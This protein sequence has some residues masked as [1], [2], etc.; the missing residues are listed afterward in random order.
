M[1]KGKKIL[2]V[3][4]EFNGTGIIDEDKNPIR[5]DDLNL[6][7]DLAYEFAQWIKWYADHI[8]DSEVLQGLS[9]NYLSAHQFHLRP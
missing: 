7:A 3:K 9:N 6:P 8:Y 4:A 2:T 1:Q 5:Y